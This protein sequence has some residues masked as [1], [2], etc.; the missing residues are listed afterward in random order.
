MDDTE[1]DVL[2]EAEAARNESLPLKSSKLY[3]QTYD[4]FNKWK[5]ANKMEEGDFSE[6]TFLAY[7]RFLSNKKNR[8]PT[9]LWQVY[10]M[11]KSMVKKKNKI[12]IEQY[13]DLHGYLSAKSKG[14][15]PQK[16]SVFTDE[17]I[18][19]FISNAPD[20]YFLDVKACMT[21]IYI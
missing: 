20:E 17:Q 3:S 8:V 2:K 19:E 13:S 9:S 12:N 15:E 16:A 4:T 6:D 10:S 11:L 21:K 7:F 14:Y 5:L 1:F 18:G